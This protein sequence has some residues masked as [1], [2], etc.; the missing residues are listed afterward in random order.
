MIVVEQHIKMLN[1]G[2]KL[3]PYFK[4]MN[5]WI[6]ATYMIKVDW[7]YLLKIRILQQLKIEVL[8]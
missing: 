1:I 5:G 3:I 7:V 8:L 2:F 4:D 6:S